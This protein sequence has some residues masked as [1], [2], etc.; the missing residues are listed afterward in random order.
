MTR[1]IIFAKYYCSFFFISYGVPADFM[2]QYICIGE[3]TVIQ[4]QWRSY[5]MSKGSADP[6][7]FAAASNSLQI[8]AIVDPSKKIA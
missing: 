8:L 5:V 7:G 4:S 3:S 6:N 1:V 2:D